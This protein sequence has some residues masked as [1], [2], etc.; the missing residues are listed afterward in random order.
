MHFK[1]F[2]DPNVLKQVCE[3]IIIPNLKVRTGRQRSS[4]SR[5]TSSSSSTS[6]KSQQCYCANRITTTLLCCLPLMSPPTS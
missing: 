4:R 3:S 5:A 2:E 6:S 1:L